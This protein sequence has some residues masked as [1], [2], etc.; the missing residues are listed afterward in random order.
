MCLQSTAGPGRVR[1][2]VLIPQPPP[3]C[4]HPCPGARQSPATPCLGA[5]G[6]MPDPSWT[7]HRR[8]QIPPRS[9]PDL[10]RTSPATPCLGAHGSI[11]NTRPLSD[12]PKPH[13]DP[14]QTPPR[15][16]GSQNIKK[17]G[18]KPLKC[19]EYHIRRTAWRNP[20]LPVGSLQSPSDK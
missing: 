2:W 16:Q 19:D 6:S 4:S 17:I 9:L 10:S 11:L 7:A 1:S 13:P 8:T 18:P 12:P 20:K 5:H 3:K 14:C 15:P